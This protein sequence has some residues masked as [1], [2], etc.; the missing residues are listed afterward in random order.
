M[1][2][3]HETDRETYQAQAREVLFD[4]LSGG[5][6]TLI[7]GRALARIGWGAEEDAEQLVDTMVTIALQ[8]V[9]GHAD[10]VTLLRM[11]ARPKLYTRE[12]RIEFANVAASVLDQR[13]ANIRTDIQRGFGSVGQARLIELMDAPDE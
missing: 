12:D 9:D 4:D 1:T 11:V 2:A 8:N 10:L 3:L 13:L 6:G 5:P 7:A